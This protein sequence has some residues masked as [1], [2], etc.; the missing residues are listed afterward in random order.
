MNP[1]NMTNI[2]EKARNLHRG[3]QGK[4]PKKK[5]KAKPS[6]SAWHPSAKGKPTTSP[7][8]QDRTKGKNS[9]RAYASPMM[10]QKFR[11]AKKAKPVK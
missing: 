5:A 10:M 2:G 8:K 7:P 1:F 6:P 9:N 3:L 11:D 4:P